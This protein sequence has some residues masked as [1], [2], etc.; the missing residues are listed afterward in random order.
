MDILLLYPSIYT[1]PGEG[2]DEDTHQRRRDSER[3]LQM[4]RERHSVFHLH[5]ST[6]K[7][8]NRTKDKGLQKSTYVDVSD[9]SVCELLILERDCWA[10]CGIQVGD[11]GR[12]GILDGGEWRVELNVTRTKNTYLVWGSCIRG[13]CRSYLAPSGRMILTSASSTTA[14]GYKVCTGMPTMYLPL[15]LSQPA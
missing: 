5:I 6:A 8:V 11:V 2:Q 10:T 4:R 9:V 12:D 14:P 1:L 15:S 7:I 13:E 3:L